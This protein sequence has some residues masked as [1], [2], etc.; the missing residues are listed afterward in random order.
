MAYADSGVSE[1]VEHGVHGL[2][3]RSP[4]TFAE[5]LATLLREDAVRARMSMESRRNLERFSWPRCAERYERVY[6]LACERHAQR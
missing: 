3:A 2:L 4:A 6:A 1:V 5:H